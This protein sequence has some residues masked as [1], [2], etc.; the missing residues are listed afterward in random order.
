MNS[1]THL[2]IIPDGNRRWAKKKRTPEFFGHREGVKSGEAILRVAL[3]AGILYLTFWG[4]SL[5]NVQK[6]S[7]MELKFLFTIF[8]KQFKKLLTSKEIFENDVR[9]DFIGRWREMFPAPIKK[10]MEEVIKKTV[11]HTKHHL[12]FLMA[13]NGF[14]EMLEAIRNLRGAKNIDF[15]AVKNNLW[16]KNLPSVDLVVRTGGDPHWSNGFLMWDVGN[17]HLHFTETLWPDFSPDEFERIIEDFG[18]NG[19]RF[20]K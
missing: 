9:V 10:V 2:A 17:A 18:K 20:G 15:N 6:R 12:T 1:L 16:T 3:K 5:D 14:D 19:R 13:Y 11:K 7:K 4:L 8:E